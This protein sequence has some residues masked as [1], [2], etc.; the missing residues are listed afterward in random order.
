VHRARAAEEDGPP[1][2]GG[3]PRARRR[4]RLGRPQR[5][6]RPPRRRAL[7][8]ELARERK[9][10]RAGGAVARVPPLPLGGLTQRRRRLPRQR[11]ADLARVTCHCFFLGKVHWVRHAACRCRQERQS[12]PPRAAP[13]GVDASLPHGAAPNAAGGNARG[14]HA[15]LRWR[16]HVPA[17]A[18]TC[19]CAGPHLCPTLPWPAGTVEEV[20]P[21]RSELPDPRVANVDQVRAPLH[22]TPNLLSGSLDVIS[23]AERLPLSGAAAP[24]AAAACSALGRR[25]APRHC[26]LGPHGRGRPPGAGRC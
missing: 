16:P 11:A 1:R 15:R 23:L 22:V 2:A 26:T 13:C 5:C 25:R 4:R 12:A 7:P 18:P 9:T 8:I 24:A 6:A 14:G 20:L 21:R 3:R 19:A 10:Q 17:R